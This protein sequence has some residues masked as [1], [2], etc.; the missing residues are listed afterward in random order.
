MKE[1][2]PNTDDLNDLADSFDQVDVTELAGLEEIQDR[3]RRDLVA[4][5]V[6]LPREDVEELKR[7]AARMG[8]VH[9]PDP[10]CGAA[11]CGALTSRAPPRLE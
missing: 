3:P 10:G 7:R 11:F 9:Q 1:Y 6:R 8:W 4:V 2:P 5:T